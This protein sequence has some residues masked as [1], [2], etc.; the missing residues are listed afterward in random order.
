[1]TVLD[2]LVV[3]ILAA[4]V[5]LSLMRGLVMEIFSLG[6]WIA[7]FLAAKWGAASVAPFLPFSVESEGMRYFAGFAVLFVA[8]LFALMLL[9]RLLKGA[10]GAAGLGGADRLFGAA[11]GLLRGVVILAGL[12]LAAGLTALPQT[13]AW[14]NAFSSKVLES[15]ALAAKPLLPARLVE[16]IHFHR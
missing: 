7:A 13:E 11:F 15:L 8:A 16:H 9:G 2:W 10:V 6:A 4:S 5:V 1:M 3:L 12:A 14:K